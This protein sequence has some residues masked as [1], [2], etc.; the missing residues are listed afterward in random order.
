MSDPLTLKANAQIREEAA[1]WFV[2]FS[3]GEVGVEGREAFSLWL[4][5]SPEHV[6]AYLQVS[7]TFQT[8]GNLR[9]HRTG[10][11]EALIERSLAKDN[12]RKIRQFPGIARARISLAVAT[13][14]R[15]SVTRGVLAASVAMLVL[16]LSA[17]ALWNNWQR[18]F[19][20][21]GIGEQR[22]VNLEDGS[23]IELNAESRI[24]VRL[25]AHQRT[26]DLLDGQALFHVAKDPQRPFIVRSDTTRVAAVGTQFD[27]NREA[28]NTVVTVLDGRVAV[29]A[30]NRDD[31]PL[32]A[33]AGEQVVLTADTASKSANPDVAAA[34]AWRERK[35]IFA[36][37]PLTQV[38]TEYNRFHQKRLVI[39]DTSLSSFRISGV[40]SANDAQA[41]IVF[42]RAQSNIEVVEKD[43]EIVLKGK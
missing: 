28:S 40:F 4:K 17:W 23:T 41:L 34:T 39:A 12:V 7:A 24:R 20:L 43:R 9:H 42:L 1:A 25:S 5:A 31:P 37:S 13:S 36:G 26:V 15:R 30:S 32:Y 29:A 33:S 8:L 16:G 6:R 14:S 2:D 11:A 38:I 27:V 22:V 35:L 21:T 19:Y 3:E 18:S 10:N